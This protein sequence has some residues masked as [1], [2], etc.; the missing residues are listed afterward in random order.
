M[1]IRVS[2]SAKWKRIGS[3]TCSNKHTYRHAQIHYSKAL[4]S[5]LLFLSLAVPMPRFF[6]YNTYSNQCHSHTHY[7]TPHHTRLTRLWQNRKQLTRTHRVGWLSANVVLQLLG[8]HRRCGCCRHC[9]RSRRLRDRHQ[10]R[11]W[12]WTRQLGL[13]L[14]H[15]RLCICYWS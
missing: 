1:R 8:G 12:R 2:L 11:R 4:F 5:F 7:I 14:V 13:T 9:C 15:F 6:S 10:H 3:G